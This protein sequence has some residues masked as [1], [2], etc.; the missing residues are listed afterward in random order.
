M[1]SFMKQLL[2][3]AHCADPIRAAKARIACIL[4]PAYHEAIENERSEKN[5]SPHMMALGLSA[6]IA[7][8]VVDMIIVQQ[9]LSDPTRAKDAFKELISSDIDEL[10][11]HCREGKGN[12]R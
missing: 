6:T 11:K 10:F 3:H 7:C 12:L 8:M 4:L 1:T 5:S 9:E 2:A